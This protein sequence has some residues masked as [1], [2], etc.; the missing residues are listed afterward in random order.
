MSRD[1]ATDV[2]ALMTAAD[3][4]GGVF[5]APPDAGLV[6]TY[7]APAGRDALAQMG[8]QLSAR[9]AAQAIDQALTREAPTPLAVTLQ[10]RY[11]ALFEGI[12]PPSAVL[13][14]ESAWQP[15]ADGTVLGGTP[16]TEMEATLRAL[17]LHVSGECCEPADHLAIELAALAMA[18]RDGQ[19]RIA[20]E[21][22]R[23]L[24][25]W[26]PAFCAALTR[27][28]AGGFYGAAGDL[29]LALIRESA[30]ALEGEEAIATER[31]EGEFA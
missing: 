20:Q 14:Y 25:G 23:R 18:L 5:A 12:F 27:Q 26:V 6:E 2:S 17:D 9:E 16:V 28:D 19:K 4:L 21:L 13:P 31:I 1:T 10:R 7:V 30:A 8:E 24:Q 29:L 11:T 3:W 22:I 15:G